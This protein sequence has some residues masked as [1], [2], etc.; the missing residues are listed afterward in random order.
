MG[1]ENEAR[2]AIMDWVS[3]NNVNVVVLHAVVGA[4]PGAQARPYDAIEGDISSF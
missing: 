4:A 1:R 2:S 3:R